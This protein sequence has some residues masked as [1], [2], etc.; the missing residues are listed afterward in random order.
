ARPPRRG[1][2]R[3]PRL[4][5][6]LP[7]AP[8]VAPTKDVEGRAERPSVELSER[9]RLLLL[10]GL[11]Q[12]ATRAE[13]RDARSCDLHALAGARIDA[14]AGGAVAGAELAE[15]CEC[16]LLASAQRFGDRVEERVDGLVGVALAQLSPVGDLFHELLL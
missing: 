2:R 12:L 11:L 7:R 5:L 10:D 13:L 6:P 16:N 3:T 15:P 9:R 4:R 8:T 14:L 1:G